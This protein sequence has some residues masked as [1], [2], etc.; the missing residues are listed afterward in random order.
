MTELS[1]KYKNLVNYLKNLENA[2]VAFSSG[3]DSTYLLKVAHDVLGDSVTAFTAK[4]ALFTKRELEEAEAFC[5]KEGIRHVIVDMDIDLIRDN[6]T[7]RCYI[8]KR[9]M[10]EQFLKTAKISNIQILLEGSNVDDEKDYRP[11]MMAIGELGI[12]SPLKLAGLSKNEVRIL[13]KEAGLKTFDKPSF[14][15]LASR[16]AY[17]EKISEEK[18]NRIQNAE[19]FLF[20]LGFTQFRVRLHGELARIEVLPVDFGNLVS[21]REDIISK[22]KG[23]GFKYISMDLEGYRTGSMN[24]AFNLK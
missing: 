3:V 23:L 1:L 15:C 4:S 5:K 10:F 8:C 11:G 12:K 20:D 18:L 22:L 21:H 13:S 2:G 14:A 16:V 19:Q 9:N 6:P 24:E 7:N 17:G